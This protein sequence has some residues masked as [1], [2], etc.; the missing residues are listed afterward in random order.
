VVTL[1]PFPDR[2][3]CSDVYTVL[4]HWRYPNG[5]IISVTVDGNRAYTVNEQP[6]RD[7]NGLV[8]TITRSQ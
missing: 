4:S 7:T 3:K 8:G 6:E 2:I 5:V 1:I